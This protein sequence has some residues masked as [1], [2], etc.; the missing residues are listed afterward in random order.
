MH[1]YAN[2]GRR[3]TIGIGICVYF[4]CFS[5]IVMQFV[6]DL[7]DIVKPLNKS[8]PRILLHEAKYLTNQEKYFHIVIMQE[9]IGIF[10][11]GTTGVA[12]ETFSLV[13]ALHAF[14]LFK[15][16]S[17]RMEHMLRVDV[18]QLS[19][20][21]NYIILHDK[22]TAAVNIHRRALEFS[23]LLKTSFGFSYLFMVVTAIFTATISLFRLFRIIMMQQNKI[24]ILKLICYVIF[25]FLLLVI[26]NFVGQEFINHDSYVHRAICNTK[27]Y[28]APL[29]IQKF[30]LFLMRKTTKSYKVDAGGLFSPSLEVIPLNESR[31]LKLLGLTT[32]LF[33]EDEYFVLIFVHMAVALSVEV[34]TV[35]ATET[36]GAV[37]IQHA[38]GLFRITSLRIKHAF[39]CEIHISASEKYK[40]YYT[41]IINALTS[42]IKAIEYFDLFNSSLEISAF[43]LLVLGVASLSLNLFRVSIVVIHSTIATYYYIDL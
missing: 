15:I 29:K 30:I 38:Y 13:N 3:S 22:I 6:P 28:N 9:V 4:G 1:K 18:S 20:A 17:Y 36:M 21:K 40:I 43:I 7:L 2:I 33:D 14:A 27:W 12:A 19:P 10:I 16:A 37:Y 24:E 11:T 5:F 41:N 32:F 39:D 8:R 25:L 26:G 23:E 31:P 34:T 35:V 42:H